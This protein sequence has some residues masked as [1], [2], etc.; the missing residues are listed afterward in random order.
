MTYPIEPAEVVQM[1]DRYVE[2]AHRDAEQ[3]SNVELLDEGQAFS[4]HMLAAEVYALAWDHATRAAESRRIGRHLRDRD[5]PT[6]PAPHTHAKEQD[7]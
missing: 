3:A 7:R 4:L 2:K 1:V 5:L 6:S